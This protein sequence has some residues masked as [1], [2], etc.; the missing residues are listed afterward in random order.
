[1]TSQGRDPSTPKATAFSVQDDQLGEINSLL[2][3]TAFLK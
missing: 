1:M 2:R 3:V